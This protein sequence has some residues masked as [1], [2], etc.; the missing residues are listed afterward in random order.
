MTA[1]EI[2]NLSLQLL[3]WLAMLATFWVYYRQLHTMQNA[4]TA[5][6][7]LSLINYLQA[8]E[9]QEARRLVRKHL[10]GK[11]H[12]TW[13]PDEERAAAITCSSYDVAAILIRQGLIPAAPFLENWGPSV[14]HCYEVLGDY[15]R[16]MQKNSG[17]HYWNDFV[18]L[19]SEV[20]KYIPQ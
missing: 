8:K 4:S 15:L 1:Y 5:Q 16:E 3:V 13:T 12:T 19:N 10:V 17:P 7:F 9:V 6:N 11:P 20:A 18:W 14:K 2:A